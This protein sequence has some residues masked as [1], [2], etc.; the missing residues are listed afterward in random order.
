[1]KRSQ[2]L[3]LLVIG[4]LLA[5]IGC[6][7]ASDGGGDGDAGNSATSDDTAHQGDDWLL[8]IN[9]NESLLHDDKRSDGRRGGEARLRAIDGLG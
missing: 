2:L 7:P 4:L 6:Q 3:G 1:M 9:A 8:V 5:I